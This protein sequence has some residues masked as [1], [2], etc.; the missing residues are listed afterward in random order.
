MSRHHA[1]RWARTRRAVL[2][3][4]GWWCRR[5]GRA[6]RMEVDHVRPLRAGGDP[7]DLANLQT[8]CRGCHVDKTAGENR[9]PRTPAEA[10]WRELVRA[11]L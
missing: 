11:M 8:L 5:C 6:G 1:G 10:A 4:D 7:W 2:D 9:R 3:R